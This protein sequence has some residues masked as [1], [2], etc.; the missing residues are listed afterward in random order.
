M[1]SLILHPKE[2]TLLVEKSLVMY[3]RL[4]LISEED[5]SVYNCDSCDWSDATSNS[6]SSSEGLQLSPESTTQAKI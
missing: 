4:T 3:N 1:R 6:D 2:I 5:P